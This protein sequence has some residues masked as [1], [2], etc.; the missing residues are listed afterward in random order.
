MNSIERLKLFTDS[1]WT[2]LLQDQAVEKFGIAASAISHNKI[3]IYGGGVSKTGLIYDADK[4]S[5]KSILG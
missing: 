1:K 3:A 5:L 4:N 2:V